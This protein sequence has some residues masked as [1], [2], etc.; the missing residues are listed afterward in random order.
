MTTERKDCSRDGPLVR[1]KPWPDTEADQKPE[2]ALADVGFWSHSVLSPLR[3]PGAKR[4]L[5]PVV[6]KLVRAN[7]W[8]PPR[9]LV[10]PF[11]GGA[12][13]ALHAAGTGAVE[14]V[15]LADANP[16]VA[17]FW[18]TAAFDTTWLINAMIEEPVTLGRWDHWKAS[19]PRRR[20]DRALKCLF[21]NRT[22]FSG[23]FD[24]HAGPIGG[25]SQTSPYA[26]GCRFGKEGLERRLRAVGDL[27]DTGRLLDVWECDWRVS[28]GM[29]TRL[30]RGLGADRVLVYLDPPYVDKAGELY[31]W[32]FRKGQHQALAAALSSAEGYNWILSYDDAPTVRDLYVG[33]NSI[34]RL[35][36]PLR[37]TARAGKRTTRNELLLTSYET[38][39]DSLGATAL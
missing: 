18:Y 15:V 26:I 14:H 37:Y 30:Y 25:R 2:F 35:V 17:A 13:T 23:I 16:L 4:Q 20:R 11:C 28:L 19:T 22:S 24:A 38:V 6:E 21:L 7:A 33:H 5:V 9:L 31:G 32:S 1:R 12:S 8:V 10:E 39:P 36:V 27:A 34:R 29:V 3:Y